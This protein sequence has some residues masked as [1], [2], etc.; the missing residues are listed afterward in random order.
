MRRPSTGGGSGAGFGRHRAG[1]EEA[2]EQLYRRHWPRAHRAATWSSTTPRRPRT[3]RRRRSW[4]R[5]GR[6]TAS[7]AAARSGPGCTGSSSTGRSTGRAPGRCARE[8]GARAELAARRPHDR[9]PAGLGD[10]QTS[11]PRSRSLSPEHRAVVVLRYLL[12]Y[13]PGEIADA[14][15]A[16]ARHGQ[17]AAAPGAR[18]P[19]DAAGRGGVVNERRLTRA[20]RVTRRCRTS[21]R[22]QERGWRVVRAA[23]EARAPAFRARLRLSR[24][25][26]A[27]AVGLLIAAI[28][29]SPAG[30]KVADL[31]HD[32]VQ[33]GAAE[34][35]A[36]ADL[37]A[38]AGAPAGH[39]RQGPLDRRPGRLE[40][41]ARRLRRRDLVAARP[42]RGR[43]SRPRADRG[44]PGRDGSLVARRAP[45]GQRP[46]LVDIGSP[47]RLPRAAP[48]CGSS[49]ATERMTTCSPGTS[50]RSHRPGGRFGSHYPQV[51]WRPGR[52]RTCS[53]T[54]T[55][56]AG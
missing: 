6:S 27:L 14:A 5:C 48:P 8:V 43:H 46:G 54:R 34:R 47:S 35:P 49:L 33:P 24:L 4:R 10:S 42:V 19:A 56:A 37:A 52:G 9:A 3:S 22:P 31:V 45:P 32:V 1:S 16:A 53:P 20:A 18:P 2:L 7:I 36:G 38:R 25:A 28:A 13:T 17:L 44:G 41:A 39:L 30:A 26:I 51:R 50:H 55:V 23:F 12:E 40:A 15:R 21:A 11:S 29:L